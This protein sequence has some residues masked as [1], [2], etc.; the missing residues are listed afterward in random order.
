MGA[1][2]Y[3]VLGDGGELAATTLPLPQEVMDLPGR[4]S[5]WIVI[6]FMTQAC[7]F[8]SA[9]HTLE[10]VAPG[11]PALSWATF[12]VEVV[13]GEVGSTVREVGREEGPLTLGWQG[14]RRL[15]YRPQVGGGRQV[16]RRLFLSPGT[17]CW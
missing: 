15:V 7:Y 12:R 1:L 17:S 13:E 10:F 6:W 8:V 4:D 14:G 16:G 9:T 5:R 3:Q 11:L 2:H